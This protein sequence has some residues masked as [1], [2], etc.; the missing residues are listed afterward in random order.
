MAGCA[1]GLLLFSHPDGS[2]QGADTDTGS[3]QIVDL[4]D[5]QRGI[6]LTGTGQDICHLIRCDGIQSASERI[7]L[8]QIQVSFVLT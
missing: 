7:Q 8:D 1:L 3:S 5:F 2:K 4:I 6:D